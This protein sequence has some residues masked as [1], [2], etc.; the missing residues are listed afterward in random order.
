MILSLTEF[1][2]A[3]VVER[4]R[5]CRHVGPVSVDLVVVQLVPQRREV[6]HCRHMEALAVTARTEVAAIQ[7]RCVA[8]VGYVRAEVILHH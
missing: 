5:D 1:E 4:V 3:V 7:G 6:P 2:E 8:E